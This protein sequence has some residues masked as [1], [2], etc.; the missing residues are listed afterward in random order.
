MKVVT[1]AL[2]ARPI[3]AGL[4]Q[5]LGLLLICIGVGYRF[6]APTALIVAG[7]GVVLLGIAH[8]IGGERA[9]SPPT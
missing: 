1:S 4:L 6:G 8:E 3:Q 7:V 2:R 9:G 5:V